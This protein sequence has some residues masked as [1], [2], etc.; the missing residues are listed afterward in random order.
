MTKNKEI[1]RKAKKPVFSTPQPKKVNKPNTAKNIPKSAPPKKNQQSPQNVRKKG[2]EAP[3]IIPIKFEQESEEESEEESLSDEE[4][5]NV[6]EK[7]LNKK[8]KNGKKGLNHEEESD[9]DDD[10]VEDDD[11]DSEDIEEESDDE[12]DDDED[13]GDEEEDDDEDDEQV[14]FEKRGTLSYKEGDKWKTVGMGNFK[15]IY[16]DD[17]NGS[18]IY[19]CSD[20]DQMLCSHLILQEMSIECNEKLK[21]CTWDAHDFATDEAV[22]KNFRIQFSSAQAVKEF[23]D[24]FNQGLDLARESELSEKDIITVPSEI[25]TPEVA[26]IGATPGEENDVPFYQ[27]GATLKDLVQGALDTKE[28]KEG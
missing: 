15:V 22:R 26:G 10:D 2:K 8:M 14:L 13:D 6:L 27:Q 5:T 9:D 19:M 23:K 21:S 20:D 25:M 1:A 16:D 11:M 7:K 28:E 24:V 12:D 3:K 18:R 17:V 4:L